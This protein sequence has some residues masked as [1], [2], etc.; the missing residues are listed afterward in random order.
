MFS[1]RPVNKDAVLLLLLSVQLQMLTCQNNKNTV[2]D[3]KGIFIHSTA[4][5][6]QRSSFVS[7]EIFVAIIYSLV[8]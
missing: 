5:K 2:Y 4:Q 7:L 6:I 1:N 8:P 3:K